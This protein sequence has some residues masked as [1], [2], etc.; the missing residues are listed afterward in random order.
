MLRFFLLI[1]IYIFSVEFFDIQGNPL[2]L[3]N[4]AAEDVILV[5]SIFTILCF[6]YEIKYSNFKEYLYLLLLF[7]YCFLMS[8]VMAYFNFGQPYFYSFLTARLFLTYLSL[9]IALCLLLRKAEFNQS[10]INYF[11]V[12]IGSILILINYYIYLTKN[13][14]LVNNLEETL[15][16]RLG[17]DRFM[18]GGGSIICLA[19]YFY[20]NWKFS[21]INLVLFIML[22]SV[23]LFISKL[24]LII[25]VSKD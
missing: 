12:M 22:F 3:T 18:V 19:I 4:V 16:E 6:N 23:I 2:L 5:L 21:R 8:P 24:L 14:S 11:L 25:L 1:F 10:K 9:L 15:T 13:Y 20:T 7:I 17:G